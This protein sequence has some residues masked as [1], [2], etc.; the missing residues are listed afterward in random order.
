MQRFNSFGSASGISNP[1]ATPVKAVPFSSSGTG[2]SGTNVSPPALKKEMP[3]GSKPYYMPDNLFGDLIDVKSFGS[4]NKASK[5][6][7]SS[8]TSSPGQPMINSKK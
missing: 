2:N 6:G 3:A 4:G 8:T 7:S 5:G 1:T